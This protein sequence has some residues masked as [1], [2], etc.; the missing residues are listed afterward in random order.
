[1][2]LFRP[3]IHFRNGILA[4]A[5]PLPPGENANVDLPRDGGPASD[6]LRQCFR[7]SRIYEEPITFE[8]QQP[9]HGT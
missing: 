4:R 2:A 7:R 8:S 5:I 3:A 9:I 6:I 1:M